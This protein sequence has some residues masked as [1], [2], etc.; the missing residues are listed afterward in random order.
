MALVCYSTFNVDQV[1]LS[2][3]MRTDEDVTVIV[4]RSIIIHDRCPALTRDLPTPLKMLLWRFERQS[5]ALKA[6]LRRRVL[7]EPRGIDEAIRRVWAGYYPGQP[8]A[9]IQG[10]NQRWVMTETSPEGGLPLTVHYNTLDG[11]LLING[12]PLTR[13]PCPYKLHGTY[14]RLFNEVLPAHPVLRMVLKLTR[15]NK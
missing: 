4:E 10:P 11:S 6:E 1:H 9:A 5:H 13:L 12:S 8:W 2:A 14:R 15:Y 7:R 3:L